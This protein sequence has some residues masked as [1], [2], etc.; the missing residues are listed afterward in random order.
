MAEFLRSYIYYAFHSLTKYDYMAIGWILFLAFLLLIL[1]AIVK[2]RV[3]SY[4]L[5]L[6][7]IALLF[8]G[9]IAVKAVMDRYLRAAEAH[10]ENLKEL[11]YT[12][13]LIVEGVVKN[14][15]ELDFSRCDLA[16]LIYKKS[17][18]FLKKTAAI[19]KPIAVRFDTLD[20]HIAK[21]ETKP[22]RIIVDHFSAKDF[23]LT[24]Q[25]RCYP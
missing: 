20:E 12:D 22:F 4:S 9:P 17:D 11:K 7:G 6:M 23:N 14:S 3:L 19:L 2:K 8:T 15:S 21:G 25:P 5:L 18:N 1:A 24:L 16:L 13:S 10:V